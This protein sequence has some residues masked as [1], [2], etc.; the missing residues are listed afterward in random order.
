MR[1]I[2]IKTTITITSQPN[3]LPPPLL[4]R[5]PPLALLTAW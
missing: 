3:P 1:N 5:D 2:S 4:P